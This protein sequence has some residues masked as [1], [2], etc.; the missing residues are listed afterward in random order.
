MCA[1]IRD[2][3]Y[4]GWIHRNILE[5]FE[6]MHRFLIL[7]LILIIHLKPCVI[8]KTS[9]FMSLYWFKNF[10]NISVYQS[11]VKHVPDDSHMSGRNMQEVCSVYNV[12]SYTYAYLLVLRSYLE[13]H[14]ILSLHRFNVMCF[15]LNPDCPFLLIYCC[16]CMY[17]L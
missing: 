9:Y 2:V 7:I 4:E 10:C 16:K 1:I 3:P 6:Q 17:S 12:L 14:V 11:F 8:F 5:H 13:V 15:R